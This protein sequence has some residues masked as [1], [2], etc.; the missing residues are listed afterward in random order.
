MAQTPLGPA[1]SRPVLTGGAAA[2]GKDVI[3]EGDE[4]LPKPRSLGVALA[5][6]ALPY[7]WAGTS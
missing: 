5:S 4:E 7:L 2:K 6:V 3:V 1:A